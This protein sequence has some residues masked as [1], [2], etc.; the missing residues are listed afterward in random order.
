MSMNEFIMLRLMESLCKEGIIPQKVYDGILVDYQNDKV[1]SSHSA[2]NN[3]HDTKN[4][5]E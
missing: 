5:K 4:M 1:A 3:S 2:C